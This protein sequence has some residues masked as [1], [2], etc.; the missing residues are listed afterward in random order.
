MNICFA[1]A[2]FRVDSTGEAR[3][4]SDKHK[5][6]M[7]RSAIVMAIPAALLALAPVGHILWRR[8]QSKLSEADQKLREAQ[9]AKLESVKKRFKAETYLPRIGYSELL[10]DTRPVAG[11]EQDTPEFGLVPRGVEPPPRVDWIE[12]GGAD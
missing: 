6:D 4:V 11:P 12:T 5:Q 8:Q 7:T 3:H 9:L 2:H 10:R 1:I